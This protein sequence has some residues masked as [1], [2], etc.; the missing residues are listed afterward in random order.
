[1]RDG[2]GK[3]WHEKQLKTSKI[4]TFTGARV[5]ILWGWWWWWSRNRISR[6]QV[7]AVG[8]SLRHGTVCTGCKTRTI[9][10]GN[11]GSPFT[12]AELTFTPAELRYYS[13]F[14]YLVSIYSTSS[15]SVNLG[16]ERKASTKT[17]KNM[18]HMGTPKMPK[19]EFWLDQT[20]MKQN[21]FGFLI[22]PN[23]RT[24]N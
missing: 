8:R 13:Y 12:P 4:Q 3:T 6:T 23:Y 24:L 22:E 11:H 21:P 15:K 14:M 9:I 5:L 20:L 7:V 19:L 18:R 1:M 17:Q 16:L 10:K 2:V